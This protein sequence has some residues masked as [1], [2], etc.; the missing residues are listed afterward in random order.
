V[1]ALD[2]F[3]DLLVRKV[4][5][6]LLDT[7]ISQQQIREA[8]NHLRNRSTDD[9]A[10][11]TLVSDGYSIYERTSP[12]EVVDLLAEGQETWGIRL[13]RICQVVEGTLAEL[14]AEPSNKPEE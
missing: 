9:L 13:G 7:G 2:S 14:P 6:R 12:D 3:R 5:Q 4:V 1:Q 8:V 11:L 10:R